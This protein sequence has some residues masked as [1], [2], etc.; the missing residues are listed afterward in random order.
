MIPAIA[1]AV[2]KGGLEDSASCWVKRAFDVSQFT[3]ITILCD[4]EVRLFNVNNVISKIAN[5][6]RTGNVI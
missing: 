4:A 3:E 1:R 6:I 2:S 5:D